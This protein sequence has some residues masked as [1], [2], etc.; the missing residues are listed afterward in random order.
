MGWFN[1]E[2]AFNACCC[3]CIFV[4]RAI[5]AGTRVGFPRTA[6]WRRWSERCLRTFTVADLR[7]TTRGW[8]TEWIYTCTVLVTVSLVSNVI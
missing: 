8:N 3:F 6:E 2:D 5:T 4:A 7:A 1:K